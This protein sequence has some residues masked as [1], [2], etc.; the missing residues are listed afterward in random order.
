MHASATDLQIR[1]HPLLIITSVVGG[2]ALVV[3]PLIQYF[4]DFSFGSRLFGNSGPLLFL[5]LLCL[6]LGIRCWRH[7]Y[8]VVTREQII[9]QWLF[10]RAAT[11]FPIRSVAKLRHE[12][13]RFSYDDEQGRP[14]RLPLQK[15]LA[16]PHG[17]AAFEQRLTGAGAFADALFRQETRPQYGLYL[18]CAAFLAIIALLWFPLLMAP[19][20]TT[21]SD[22]NNELTIPQQALAQ[23]AFAIQTHQYGIGIAL[24]A[25]LIALGRLARR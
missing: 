14:Q 22:L 23:L 10:G 20:I 19:C 9:I 17:W 25:G 12:H 24:I 13:G 16:H 11:T 1:F 4:L 2:T 5:G 18:G 7:P 15:F 6:R 3:T 21:W 8:C